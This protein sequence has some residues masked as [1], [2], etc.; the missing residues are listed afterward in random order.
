MSNSLDYNLIE[1]HTYIQLQMMMKLY[2]N[3]TCW[4]SFTPMAS[5]KHGSSCTSSAI[6]VFNS[7]DG[8]AVTKIR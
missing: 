3:V 2:F 4:L 6:F 8:L 5:A 1:M 7:S